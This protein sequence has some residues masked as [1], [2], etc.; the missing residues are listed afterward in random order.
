LFEEMKNQNESKILNVEKVL[1]LYKCVP[2]VFLMG[3][4]KNILRTVWHFGVFRF[5]PVCGKISHPM[6]K[7]ASPKPA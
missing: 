1:L 2:C 4:L 6:V 3:K 7:T 5:F